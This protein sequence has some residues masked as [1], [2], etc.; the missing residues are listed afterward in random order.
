MLELMLILPGPS[1]RKPVHFLRML[2]IPEE[3]E[4]HENQDYSRSYE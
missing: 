4:Q 1:W 2:L 3:I